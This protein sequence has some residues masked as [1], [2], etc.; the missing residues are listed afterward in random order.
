MLLTQGKAPMLNSLLDE[1]KK[2]VVEQDKALRAFVKQEYDN[3]VNA[4]DTEY[5]PKLLEAYSKEDVESM[6]SQAHNMSL[7]F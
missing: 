2:A 4:L 7:T 5:S 6:K 1:K 3:I